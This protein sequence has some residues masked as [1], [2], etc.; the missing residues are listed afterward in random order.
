MLQI[1]C[2]FCGPRDESEFTCGGEAHISRPLAENCLSDKEFADYLF[3]RHN[4]KGLFLER[5]RHAAGCRRWF[6]IARDTHSHEII[7]V[8]AMGSKPKTAAARKAYEQNW[9]RG[10]AAEAAARIGANPAGANPAGA[11]QKNRSGK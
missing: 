2:P 7:E 8:Y 9:R 4:P 3:Y 10:T 6:N 1:N 11:K 5:W